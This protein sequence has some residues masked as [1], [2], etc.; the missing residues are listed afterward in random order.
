MHL[1]V[2]WIIVVIVQLDALFGNW[3]WLSGLDL[4]VFDQAEITVVTRFG[5]GG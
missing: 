4:G 2:A 1:V 5:Q 3:E